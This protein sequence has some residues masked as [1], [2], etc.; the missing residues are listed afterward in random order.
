LKTSGANNATKC[1]ARP[2]WILIETLNY[3]R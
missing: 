1:V 3:V 2:T